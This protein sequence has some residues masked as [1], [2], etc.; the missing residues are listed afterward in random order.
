MSLVRKLKPDRSFSGA[1]IPLSMSIIFGVVSLIFGITEGFLVL[2]VLLW[3]IALF[4]LY[5]FIRTVNVA[6]LVICGDLIYFGIMVFIFQKNFYA[7]QT[8]RLEFGLAYFFGLLFFGAILIFLAVNRKLK[9]RG[10][11]IFE[12]AAAAVE[13][14]GDGYT[15]RPKP[16]GKVD[17]STHQIQA[18]ARFAARNLIALPYTNSGN[19]TLVLVKMGEGFER[20]LGLRGDYYDATWV[21]FDKNGEVSVHISQR[22]YLD[23]REPLAFDDLCT[24]LGQVFI[25][26]LEMFSRG[27]GVRVI[28][29]LDDLKIP[30]FS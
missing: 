24:A 3:I 23:F 14:T 6:Q 9:W 16:I 22:D 26:F 1:I 21:N 17:F 7:N 28:D 27:E 25:D 10:R 18:F 13:E 2:A 19:I 11:D 15:S 12:L 4:Y 5:T 30:I 29:R 8:I 20:L